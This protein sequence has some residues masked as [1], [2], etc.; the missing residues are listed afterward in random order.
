MDIHTEIVRFALALH[1]KAQPSHIELHHRLE[2]DLGLDPLDLVL[3]VLRLE[4]IEEAEFPVADLETVMT[5]GDLVAVVRSWASPDR[6]ASLPP[7]PRTDSG[8]RTIT[9]D[10]RACSAEGV[11]SWREGGRND[12]MR[13]VASAR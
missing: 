4:E 13:R 1:L 5:V 9:E 7:P 12:A 10:P 2:Q 8:F 3:V 6:S 11:E